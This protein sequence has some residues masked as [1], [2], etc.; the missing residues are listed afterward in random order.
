MK[1]ILLLIIITVAC[2][3][4]VR[5]CQSQSY[6]PGK[7][8]YQYIIHDSTMR[9]PLDT[10]ASSPVGS[11][12]YKNDSLFFKK[13]NGH[14]HGI[15][16]GGSM[17]TT[18]S[19]IFATL[20]RLDT[21]KVNLRIQIAAKQPL[22]NYITQLNSDVTATGPG[23]V[24]ATIAAN[25][26]SNAK[27]R[28]SAGTSLV[29]RSAGSTGNVADIVSTV[30]GTYAVR[31]AG[32]IVIDS[33]QYQDIKNTPSTNPGVYFSPGQNANAGFIVFATAIARPTNSFVNG[34]PILWEI[35]NYTS[36]HN[37]SFFDSAYG[38]TSN[39]RLFLRTPKVKY[40]M[41]GM[42]NPDEVFALQN[43]IAGPSVGV[44][45]LQFPV[46]R[47]MQLGFKLTGNG[48][49]TWTVASSFPSLITQSTYNTSTG[50]T[51]FNLGASWGID[52]NSPN[53]QYIGTHNFRIRR[54]YSA[55]G[56]YNVGFIIV[57]EFNNPVTDAPS[58]SDEIVITNGGTHT[59]QVSMGTWLNNINNFMNTASNWWVYGVFECWLVAAPVSTTSI[60]VRWQTNYPSATTYKISRSSTGLYGTFTLIHTGTEGTYID[61]GLTANTRYTYKMVAVVAGVDTDVTTFTTNTIF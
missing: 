59:I 2:N 25:A 45:D 17:G 27:F 61:A 4:I 19:A 9:P 34:N 60:Q 41:L 22:G 33:I 20:Y 28:Q 57:D 32:A 54:Q 5:K 36:D 38:N 50:F 39:G 24:V 58:T 26:V 7:F 35:I 6:V 3:L 16:G 48:A 52:Y 30:D 10:L 42:V 14:W 46:H 37:S 11:I 40:V 49:G 43:C 47:S 15:G 23:N 53:I 31:R 18:D 13:I 56:I 51:G 8:R 29:G 12:A 21:A 44:T 1:R 55:L